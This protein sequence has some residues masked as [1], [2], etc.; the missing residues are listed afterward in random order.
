MVKKLMIPLI[1][2]SAVVVAVVA[3]AI[4]ISIVN[5][6]STNN[7]GSNNGGSNNNG[8]N[9]NGSNNNGSNNNGSNNNGSNNN[10]SNNNGSNNNGSNNNGSNN[11]GSNNNG[12]NNGESN[13]GGETGESLITSLRKWNILETQAI[14]TQSLSI[15]DITNSVIEFL[16]AKQDEFIKNINASYSVLKP[17]KRDEKN[18]YI[19]FT[20]PVP[21]KDTS[22]LNAFAKTYFLN[23]NNWNDVISYCKSKNQNITDASKIQNMEI[24]YSISKDATNENLVNV[25]PEQLVV[26]I[27]NKEYLIDFSQERPFSSYTLFVGLN[28]NVNSGAII[29][30]GQNI[31]RPMMLNQ[32][33]FDCGAFG[34]L[35]QNTESI[36]DMIDK[37][38]VTDFIYLNRATIFSNYNDLN[39]KDFISKVDATPVIEKSQI[40]VEISYKNVNVKT[41]FAIQLSDD[42]LLRFSK[43][44]DIKNWSNGKRERIEI[45]Y[46]AIS[47]DTILDEA[48]KLINSRA[49]KEYSNYHHIDSFIKKIGGQNNAF[50]MELNPNGIFNNSQLLQQFPKIFSW[51]AQPWITAVNALGTFPNVNKIKNIIVEFNAQIT[52]LDNIRTGTN[53]DVKIVPL[54]TTVIFDS[55]TLSNIVWNFSKDLQNK[56]SY[57]LDFLLIVY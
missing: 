22:E 29:E 26:W 14:A 18:N 38:K 4:P 43:L 32:E 30:K 16:Y 15:S 21:Y 13:N 56:K 39:N 52:G 49:K 33:I 2:G 7:G 23:E 31:L 45:G 36:T 1:A 17:T 24:V 34:G 10:G 55:T 20:I 42:N 46:S 25:K 47:K 50:T 28:N 37:T 44:S 57:Q 9:N 41:N 48:I 53:V 40:S 27:E 5:S 35:N 51:E 19:S 54:K 8:S 3:T 6:Q 11:N 12:S